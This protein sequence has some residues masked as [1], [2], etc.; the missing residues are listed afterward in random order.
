MR[1]LDPGHLYEVD[2]YDGPSTG[3]GARVRR[4][5]KRIGDDYPGNEPP[6][7]AGT[8]CQ[9]EIRVLI[10]RVRYLDGQDRSDRNQAIVSHLSDALWQFELRAAERRGELDAFRDRAFSWAMSVGAGWVDGRPARVETIPACPTCGHVLCSKHG[11]T[12]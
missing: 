8:N 10:D 2:V 11:D 9:E 5:M 6:G 4:F 1:V 7:Y 12:A 3:P